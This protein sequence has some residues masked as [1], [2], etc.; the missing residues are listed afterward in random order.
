MN[1]NHTNTVGAHR[2]RES[3]RVISTHKF[4]QLGSTIRLFEIDTPVIY[5]NVIEHVDDED[6]FTARNKRQP[7]A[8]NIE[9]A[10]NFF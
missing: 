10:S 7:G 6:I 3:D 2:P 5:N 8:N 1:Y 9:R 4:I